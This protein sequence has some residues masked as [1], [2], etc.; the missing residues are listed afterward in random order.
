[1][2]EKCNIENEKCDC[3][4]AIKNLFKASHNF[5]IQ[6]HGVFYNKSNEGSLY[7]DGT[8]NSIKKDDLVKPGQTFS[9]KWT[10][11]QHVSPTKDDP[12]CLTWVY[13]S[14]VDPIKDV[15]SGNDTNL[16]CASY[17]ARPKARITG[18][19]FPGPHVL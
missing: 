3:L 2:L 9:Y 11:P 12:D 14:A 16:S 15:Y 7:N 6:P 18:A 5:S 19:N 10:V 4:C 13:S 17:Q 1:M 8:S